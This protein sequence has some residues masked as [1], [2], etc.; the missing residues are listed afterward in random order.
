MRLLR[1]GNRIALVF[2]NL[3]L[4]LAGVYYHAVAPHRP[5]VPEGS[6]EDLLYRANDLAWNDRWEEAKPLYKRAEVLFTAQRNQ[7]KV[8]Y[9]AVSQIPPDESV[10]I[11]ATIVHPVYQQ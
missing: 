5:S 4:M 3:I 1:I 10:D 6:A 8:L 11:P 7:S 9:S 2:F